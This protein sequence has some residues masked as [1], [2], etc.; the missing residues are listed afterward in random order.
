MGTPLGP[1][2]ANFYASN[3]ENKVFSQKP[4]VKPQVFCRYIDDI[5]I[6]CNSFGE[7]EL[8]KQEFEANSPLKFT[9]EIECNKNIAF[10]DTLLS[11]TEDGLTTTVF[12]KETNTGECLNYESLC[13]KR[14][15]TAVKKNFSTH[16]I[17][18][19]LQLGAF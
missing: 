1:T 3:L 6:V 5:F 15:K 13:P 7:I 19:V 10:L 11:R 14:Y 12:R 16:I 4:E 17:Q 9:Y 2:M 18:R 8:L